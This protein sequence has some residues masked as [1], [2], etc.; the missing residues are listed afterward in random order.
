[1]VLAIDEAFLPATLTA[2][3]MTD[4][5]FAGFC[6]EH[7]DLFFETTAEGE[8]LVMPA[9]FSLTGARNFEICGQL[10]VWARRNA[11][12]IAT[13]SSTGFVLPNGARRSPDAAWTPKSEIAKL[14]RESRE[15][16]WCLCPAFVIELRSQSDRLRVLRDKMREYIANGAQLAWLIDAESRTVEVYRP[17]RDPEVSVDAESVAGEGPLEGFTL[18]L[19]TVWDPFAA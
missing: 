12:G 2:P 9:A 8:L 10:R 1:M 6:D 14:S 3:P 19:R 18:D 7:P 13:D 17:N 5:E 15:G 16:Y 11:L 4:R